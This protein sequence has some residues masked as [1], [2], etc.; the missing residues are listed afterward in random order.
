MNTRE[1]IVWCVGIIAAVILILVPVFIVK[2][3]DRITDLTEA[4]SQP[5]ITS[6]VTID[7]VI[8]IAPDDVRFEVRGFDAQV[9][10]RL[11]D[12]VLNAL[13]NNDE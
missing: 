11:I 2:F 8:I 7:E 9:N 12:M 6:N 5:G 10:S 4:I 3:S 1:C 13:V